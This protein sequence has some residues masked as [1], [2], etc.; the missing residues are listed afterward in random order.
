[1]GSAQSPSS[2]RR[3]TSTAFSKATTSFPRASRAGSW[4]PSVSCLGERLDNQLGTLDRIPCLLPVLGIVQRFDGRRRRSQVRDLRLNGRVTGAGERGAKVPRL[5]HGHLDP[6][7]RDVATER[8]RETRD[9][10]LGRAVETRVREPLQ[11]ATEP[12]FDTTLDFARACMEARRGR[13]SASET[14]CIIR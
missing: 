3:N 9:R 4:C 10:E 13:R 11:P 2:W 12:T 8:L 14:R 1:M 7:M 5:N 6:K